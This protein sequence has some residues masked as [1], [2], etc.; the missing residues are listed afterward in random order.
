MMNPRHN[1]EENLERFAHMCPQ[2]AISLQDVDCQQLQFCQTAK[3]E[4]NLRRI[5][6][7]KEVYYHSQEGAKEEAEQW[8]N[9]VCPVG[10]KVIL[11]YGLGLGYVYY[12]LQDW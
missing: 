5:G 11:F 7:G 1:F 12:G 3:G 10:I 6:K 4:L 2:A 9:Q 8:L